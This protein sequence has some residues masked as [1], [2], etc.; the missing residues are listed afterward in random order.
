[1]I[2]EGALTGFAVWLHK[3]HNCSK[4]WIRDSTIP[5]SISKATLRIGE[6]YWRILKEGFYINV[7]EGIKNAFDL[8][9]QYN[10]P[11]RCLSQSCW[12]MGFLE[13]SIL[14]HLFFQLSDALSLTADW[15]VL[16][17]VWHQGSMWFCVWLS[18][19]KNF[20][21]LFDL[22]FLCVIFYKTK[23]VPRVSTKRFFFIRKGF[24]SKTQ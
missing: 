15:P 7:K 10:N 20:Q 19:P 17:E 16:Q 12:G 5:S 3:S 8:C 24:L 11:A 21:S 18:H 14:V 6:V 13:R 2:T 23:H 9:V 22:L 1:M 4:Y